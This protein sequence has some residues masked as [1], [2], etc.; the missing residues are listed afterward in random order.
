MSVEKQSFAD[1]KRSVRGHDFQWTENHLTAEQ[2][3]PLRQQAD[4][5]GLAVV[6]KLLAIVAARKEAGEKRPDLYT[7]LKEN[8]ANDSTLTEFWEETHSVPDWV[9]WE[10]IERGQTFLYRYLAP[11]ITGIVLQGCLGE[12]AVCS[13][14]I[15]FCTCT[16]L[17]P[18]LPSSPQQEPQRSSSE[19]EALTSLFCPSDSLRPSSGRFR[20]LSPWSHFSPVAKAISPPFASDSCTQWCA[21]AF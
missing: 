20:P 17:T 21:I 8:Y 11:N 2:L 10:E 3:M 19:L 14:A 13:I 9:D 5:L 16:I 6:E 15:T 1:N 4:D 7:V 12:N 18:I